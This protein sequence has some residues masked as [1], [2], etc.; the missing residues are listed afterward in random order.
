[1]SDPYGE[2]MMAGT[3]RN[4][5]ELLAMSQQRDIDEGTV[6][7]VA[8]TSEIWVWT[9]SKWTRI[10]PAPAPTEE[11]VEEFVR[12][13]LT[14]QDRLDLVVEWECRNGKYTSSE[15]NPKLS[16]FIR[17]LKQSTGFDATPTVFMFEVFRYQTNYCDTIDLCS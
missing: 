2:P 8:E 17:K 6:W 10:V 15:L 4:H 7:F 12:T 13:F 16:G 5:S 9:N 14:H 11:C 3:V 1:M